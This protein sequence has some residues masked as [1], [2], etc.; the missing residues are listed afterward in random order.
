LAIGASL[1]LLLASGNAFAQTDAQ[2]E[3]ARQHFTRGV[4]FINQSRWQDAIVELQAA[5]DIR[6]TPSVLFNLGLAQRAVGQNREAVRS[7]RQY[8][9]MPNATPNP[10][11][12]ARAE[13]YLH[14]LT[15]GVS[16]IELR[17]EPANAQVRVDGDLVAAG[18]HTV[19]VDP[20]RRVITVEAQG[21]AT[22][23]RTIDVGRGATAILSMRLQ[24]VNGG[25]RLRVT[26]NVREAEI[27]VDGHVLGTGV[28]DEAVAPGPHT[29]DV[30]AQGYSRFRREFVATA[31]A[32]TNVS[33]NLAASHT[34]FESPWF[35]VGTGV[36]VAAAVVLGVLA[37]STWDQPYEGSWG[38][39]DGITARGEGR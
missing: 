22:E 26:S 11:L 23:T 19:Q 5:R 33:A 9:D 24:S 17:I 10:E 13:E 20:G 36:V 25:A 28:V 8:L 7:F 14:E 12:R 2:R 21:Y 35:W 37:L 30:R 32:Q 4:E 3:E 15:S 39:V 38:V 18:T 34:V 29:I 31:G 6:A 27:R 16:S 1:A